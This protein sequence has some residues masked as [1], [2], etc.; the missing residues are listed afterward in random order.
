[1]PIIFL[2]NK[3]DLPGAMTTEKIESTLHLEELSQE[4]KWKVVSTNAL[5][6]TNV[7]AAFSWLS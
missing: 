3:S 1:M 2:A 4:R 6:G 5:K 7:D